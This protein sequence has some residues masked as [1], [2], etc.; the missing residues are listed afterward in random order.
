MRND[1]PTASKG[2]AEIA[3]GGSPLGN[4]IP[5]VLAS[6]AILEIKARAASPAASQNTILFALEKDK[7]LLPTSGISDARRRVPGNRHDFVEGLLNPDRTV[8]VKVHDGSQGLPVVKAIL[9]SWVSREAGNAHLNPSTTA[10]SRGFRH[11]E[12]FHKAKALGVRAELG[13]PET[14]AASSYV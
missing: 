14:R 10:D 5:A 7:F 13:M 1:K 6:K 8:I 11:A 12:I 4:P 9:D 3:A 2:R